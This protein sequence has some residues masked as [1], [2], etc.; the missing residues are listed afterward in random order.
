[1]TASLWLRKNERLLTLIVSGALILLGW[2][3]AP[4]RRYLMIAAA[5]VAGYRIA[6]TAWIALRAKV[7]SIQLLVSIAAI[8]GIFIG[9]QWEAAAV[10]FLF[11]LGNYLEA[12]TLNK[13]RDAIQQLLEMAPA[14]AI[15]LRNGAEVEE[16]P[17]E[18]EKGEL[19]LAR[20]G[21]KI[22]VDGIIVK[23]SASVN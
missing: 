13:T 8:G 5:I 2:L 15:V 14:S 1:M 18:V 17:D 10:T 20:S 7:V 4:A 6:Q 16:D 12:R 21:T 23:G 11:A 19:V 3:I 9:E 22:P